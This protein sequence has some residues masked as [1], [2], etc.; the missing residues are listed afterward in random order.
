MWDTSTSQPD[1]V[2]T[3]N[4]GALLKQLLA[5]KRLEELAVYS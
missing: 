3:G 2:N 4:I 1:R 5:V